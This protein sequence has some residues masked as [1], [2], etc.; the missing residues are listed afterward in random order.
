MAQIEFHEVAKRYANG[1]VALENLNLQIRDREFLVLLGPSG[2][3]K[4][5]TLNMIAGLEEVT[6]GSLR[7]DDV[8]VNS[9]PA[10]RRDV[11]MVFQSYALYPHKNVYE[12]IAFGLRMRRHSRDEIDVRVRAAARSLEI[13]HL[14]ERRPVQLSGGQRQRVALGRAMVRQP[15]VFLM[16][17]PLSNLD[18]ALRVSMRAG[19]KALHQSMRTTFVYVTHDQA[20][21]LTLADRIVVM[22]EG[23]VQQLG[24]PDDIYERP[25]NRFVANFLGSPPINFVE[26]ALEADGTGG[27]LFRSR[28]SDFTLVLADDVR[29]R[30]AQRAGQRVSVGIRA[31]D[32][33]E[34]PADDACTISG[35]ICSLL[36]V[37]SDQFIGIDVGGDASTQK[38]A[39]PAS[40]LM[41]FRAG[42]ERRFAMGERVAIPL[43][44]CR[45]HLFDQ[46]SGMNLALLP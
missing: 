19:I 44:R 15:A 43:N 40:Q 26:G 17:E 11:A 23:V 45:L 1:H 5:T 27:V 18:A 8:E 24:S 7:F 12:N 6:E 37:G 38:G 4:S 21:A 46:A 34:Q 39:R 13:E 29:K 22:R 30:L 2:C 14:L 35:E 32:V 28:G 10:H 9:V 16:D 31:E 25:A 42:K 20:E 3:G 33:D 41:Y 36:P